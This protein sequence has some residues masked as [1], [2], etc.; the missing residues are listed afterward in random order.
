MLGIPSPLSPLPSPLSPPPS[1]HLFLFSTNE[2]LMRRDTRTDRCTTN[3]SSATACAARRRGPRGRARIRKVRKPSSAP[4]TSRLL[5]TARV[6][7]KYPGEM[8]R[9]EEGWEEMIKRDE[10]RGGIFFYM[11]RYS[12]EHLRLCSLWKSCVSAR[13]LFPFP[14]PSPL[15]FSCFFSSLLLYLLLP[16]FSLIP[17]S[18]INLAQ[19]GDVRQQD[20]EVLPALHHGL[21]LLPA[22]EGCERHGEGKERETKG[23]SREALLRRLHKLPRELPPQGRRRWI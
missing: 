1:I 21:L 7:R 4:S 18:L 15:S 20:T 22:A 11:K 23:E 19:G 9:D 14:L 12:S 2:K 8:R 10:K 5:S 17:L 13:Y 3:S 6:L 16:Y